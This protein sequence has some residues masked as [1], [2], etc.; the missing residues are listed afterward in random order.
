M[1]GCRIL[2]RVGCYLVG[3]CYAGV[4]DS[5]SRAGV[6]ACLA[7]GARVLGTDSKRGEANRF[8]ISLVINIVDTLIGINLYSSKLNNFE[9][10]KGCSSLY[11]AHK[12][13]R[14][15]LITATLA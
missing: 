2:D 4:A 10:S 11:T 15:F 5:S 7:R 6:V 1:R 14:Y 8:G 3:C 13:V 12:P 9:L